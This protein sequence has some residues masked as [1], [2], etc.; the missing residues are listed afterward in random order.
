MK[1]FIIIS[2]VLLIGGSTWF[3]SCSVKPVNSNNPTHNKKPNIILLMGDDHGF[4]ETG[5]NGHPFIK[6]PVLDEMAENGLVF[7]RFYSAHPSCSPTR[8]SVI[9]GRHPNRYGTFNAGWSIRPEEISIASL[10]KK[11]GYV[12]GHF[13][14]WHLG[15]VKEGSPTN[16]GAMGFDTWVSHDN[17][18]ELNPVLSRNGGDPEKFEG[19]GS[20]VVVDETI[21]FIEKSNE[22][23]FF[24]VV[25]FGSPH[26]PYEGLQE[27]LA[28]YDDLPDSL[29]TKY[30]N[31][32][33]LKTGRRVTRPQDSVLQERYAE[34][35][36]MDRAIGQLRG[37]LKKEG[38]KDNTLIWYCGDN[39]IPPS[40]VQYSNLH[41]LKGTIYEGGT[42]V[43]GIVEW[44]STIKAKTVTEFNSVTSDMFPTLCELAGVSLP[45]RPYDGVSLV[46]L[47]KG[48]MDKREEPICFWMFDI[49]HL[50]SN[51]PY[52]TKS[53]Q[54]GTTPLVKMLGNSYI[55]TFQNYHH[56]EIESKDYK[57]DRSI[58]DGEFKLILKNQEK[59][60]T[61]ELYHISIDPGERE[62]LLLSYPEKAT[63]MENKLRD[64]QESVLHSLAEED[65]V[66]DKD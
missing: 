25:W 52:I 15:P 1:K 32:T 3:Y 40:G 55:R 14:K 54:I 12:T 10:L 39:G 42:R 4:E 19:E 31:L 61:K 16:P 56:K 7:N 13:G 8:G 62:N 57:G 27:D 58:L 18:F 24:A 60:V 63:E 28:L 2:L 29:S 34:I 17:F 33:S 41:S 5:Y 50:E 65:Y 53:L 66:L 48:Q 51:D 59:R 49:K 44:P 9:T 35:T 22:D 37:Y 30:F 6:T 45:D 46:P 20:M 64:W 43:P 23:P 47:I 11:A 21:R 38:L 26:E 36:A